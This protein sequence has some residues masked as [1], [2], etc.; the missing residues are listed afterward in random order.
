MIFRTKIPYS[1]TGESKEIG[2]AITRVRG[3][4]WLL[5]VYYSTESANTTTWFKVWSKRREQTR[6]GAS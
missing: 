4:C 3:G 1:R 5:A 2:M 6:C